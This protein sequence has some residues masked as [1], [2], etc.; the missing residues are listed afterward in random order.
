M[1][2]VNYRTRPAKNIQRYGKRNVTIG[3]CNIDA[4]IICAGTSETLRY[5]EALTTRRAIQRDE[6]CLVAC[7][8]T[9][10]H[11][12]QA[13]LVQYQQTVLVASGR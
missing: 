12:Y 9:D 7:N 13:A 6:Q 2:K 5:Q 3:S 8:R 11:A 10:G 1:N 4:S